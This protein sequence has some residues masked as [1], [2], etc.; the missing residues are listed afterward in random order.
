MIGVR[1]GSGD[2]RYSRPGGQRYKLV[3]A[4]W[5]KCG[6][7]NN[8]RVVKTTGKGPFSI[9][10]YAKP[11]QM[12]A[13]LGSVCAQNCLC[14]PCGV[15]KVHALHAL[16][17]W[18]LAVARNRGPRLLLFSVGAWVVRR[19]VRGRPGRRLSAPGNGWLKFV[20][21]HVLIA[22]GIGIMSHYCPVRCRIGSVG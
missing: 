9:C 11:A 17:G 12:N 5:E 3:D 22:G 13:F 2:P 14:E 15:R 20:V 1:R 21:S 4:T 7:W 8:S 18:F 10:F 19:E 6:L 16:D